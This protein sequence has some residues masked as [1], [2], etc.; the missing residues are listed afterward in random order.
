MKDDQSPSLDQLGRPF[1]YAVASGT[2]AGGLI[3]LLLSFFIVFTFSPYGD[4]EAIDSVWWDLTLAV[5]PIVVTFAI[6]LLSSLIIGLPAT[7]LL[8]RFRK[9]SSAAYVAL[10]LGAGFFLPLIILLAADAAV[11]WWIALFGAFS[12]AVTGRTWWTFGRAPLRS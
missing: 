9:E 11:L 2:V 10:G 4:P 7:A 12:G 8:A 1:C 3:P 5:S 6:V